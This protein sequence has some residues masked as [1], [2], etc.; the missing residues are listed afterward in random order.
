MNLHIIH[1]PTRAFI[2]R[3]YLLL[4]YERENLSIVPTNFDDP[5]STSRLVALQSAWDHLK[6]RT[7]K[8]SLPLLIA[9]RRFQIAEVRLLI[10]LQ[11]KSQLYTHNWTNRKRLYKAQYNPVKYVS[12]QKCCL[13]SFPKFLEDTYPE[14]DEKCKVDIRGRNLLQGIAPQR[15]QADSIAFSVGCSRG[16]TREVNEIAVGPPTPRTLEILHESPVEHIGSFQEAVHLTLFDGSSAYDPQ[17]TYTC[18]SDC[19]PPSDELLEEDRAPAHTALNTAWGVVKRLLVQDLLGHALRGLDDGGEMC[20]TSTSSSHASSTEESVS[21][22]RSSCTS[23]SRNG[24]RKRMRGSGGD[25]FDHDSDEDGSSDDRP[26]KRNDKGSP[27]H[28]P[29]SRVKCPFYQRQPEKYCKAA[30]RGEGFIDM[31]KLK[32]HIKRV[33][34]QPLR[35]FRC[36]LEMKSE[37]SFSEHLQEEVSC[38]KNPKPQDD[39]LHRRFVDDELDFKKPPYSKAKTIEEKWR[40]MYKLLF[41]DDAEIPSPCKWV[42]SRFVVHFAYS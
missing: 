27:V 4:N 37:E 38:K 20:S 25:P 2:Q 11:T 35:C 33:H 31:A 41:P 16:A 40:L 39:R 21:L 17:S 24:P 6:L 8:S 30:C 14:I 9:Y 34:T 26:K 1:A 13:D 22:G 10:F 15:R 28:P 5:I 29:R 23:S 18:A 42:H 32:D 19:G 7:G 3:A 12:H 36:W